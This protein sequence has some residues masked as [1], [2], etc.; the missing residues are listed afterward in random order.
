MKINII[1]GVVL[2]M[3]L[4]LTACSGNGNGNA[5]THGNGSGDNSDFSEFDNS[6]EYKSLPDNYKITT[7]LGDAKENSGATMNTEMRCGQGF[8]DKGYVEGEGHSIITFYEVPSGL[9][10]TLFPDDKRGE[11]Q[12]NPEYFYTDCSQFESYEEYSSL[13]EDESAIGQE[14]IAGRITA[15]YDVSTRSQEHKI[16]IDKEY[17]FCMK[18]VINGKLICEVTEFEANGFELTDMVNL[19]E[20]TID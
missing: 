3:I 9:V 16:W 18:E 10:Y 5:D 8:V 2:V 12:E 14:K 7:K 15:I 6:G 1:F 20:Y 19:S 17:G 13:Y 4:S 11:I